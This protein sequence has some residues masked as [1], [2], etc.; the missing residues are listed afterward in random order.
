MST[1]PGI[2]KQLHEQFTAMPKETTAQKIME[3]YFGYINATQVQEQLWELTH[4][5]ITNNLLKDTQTAA[6]RHNLIFFYEYTSLFINAVYFLQG[7]TAKD[8]I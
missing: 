3:Q 7:K 6:H 1:L 8:P 4:G 2:L 5:T